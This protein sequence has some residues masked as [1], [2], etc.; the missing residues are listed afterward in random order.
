MRGVGSL[1]L[2]PRTICLLPVCL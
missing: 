1:G 2:R